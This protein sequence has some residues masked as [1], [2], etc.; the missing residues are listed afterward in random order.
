MGATTFDNIIQKTT[1]IALFQSS[2]T[3]CFRRQEILMPHNHR[4]LTAVHHFTSIKKHS[5]LEWLHKTS[6]TRQKSRP[7]LS[8]KSHD[9]CFFDCED[10]YT[11][12]I[13]KSTTVAVDACYKILQNLKMAVKDRRHGKLSGGIKLLHDNTKHHAA[14]KHKLC[15]RR[16]QT[17]PPRM[18]RTTV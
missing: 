4:T 14:H 1:L 6:S 12:F 2:A 13:V 18:C 9:H 7:T 5:T 10:V 15:Y 11:E 17:Q 8:W 3:I 16:N